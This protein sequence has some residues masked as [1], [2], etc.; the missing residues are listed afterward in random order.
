MKI[1]H[2]IPFYAPAWGYGGPVRVCYDL[3]NALSD[4]GHSITVLT[5]D[6]YD[7]TRRINKDCE[8]TGPAKV[9]RF[10]NLSNYLAKKY[11]FFLP[12]GFS[13][14]CKKNIKHADIV[15]LHSF[16]T[17]LNII[18]AKY[19]KKNNIPY[20]IHFHESIR[21]T[22]ERGKQILKQIFIKLWGKRILEN[23][24][25]IIV[26]SSGELEELN[27]FDSRLTAKAVIIANPGPV[28]VGIN[29]KKIS[30]RK[31]YNYSKNDKI[32]LSLSRL[33][34]LKGIDMLIKTFGEIQKID[35]SFKLIIAGPSEP[36]VREELENLALK[37]DKNNVKFFGMADQ[38]TKEDFYSI[39]DF[40]CLFSRYESFGV[41][42]LE[43]LSHN[44]PVFLN[45]TVGIARDIANNNCI[46]IID[47]TDSKATSKMIIQQF[48]KKQKMAVDCKDVLEKYS[49]EKIIDKM[50]KLYKGVV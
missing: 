27:L 34:R 26:L 30:I 35:N 45:K 8:D 39:A 19:A 22:Q 20:I 3:A 47:S 36:G 32:L 48:N 13:N 33:S 41:T 12:L 43:A 28:W 25:S 11:N 37:T 9:K 38:S 1:V 7:H 17:I 46:K 44:L 24:K 14:Y 50:I 18:G 5:T 42:I 31:K 10:R 16:Y 49:L 4:K 23:A 15:H 2:V 29:P 40:Y 21:P 6:A